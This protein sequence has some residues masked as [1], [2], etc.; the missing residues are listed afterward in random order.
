[1]SNPAIP[2]HSEGAIDITDRSRDAL[3]GSFISQ[4]MIM[5]IIVMLTIKKDEKV[6]CIVSDF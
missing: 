4:I 6:N 2:S 3:S 1:M 5:M